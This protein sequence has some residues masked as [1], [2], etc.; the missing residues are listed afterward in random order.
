MN[1]VSMT[2]IPPLTSSNNNLSKLQPPPRTN[3]SSIES[4]M[5]LVNRCGPAMPRPLDPFTS[6]DL[7]NISSVNRDTDI[8]RGRWEGP[9]FVYC[10]CALAMIM[11]DRITYIL[12]IGV[13]KDCCWP[14]LQFLGIYSETCGRIV[15]S[16]TH[17]KTYHS[18]LFR[19]TRHWELGRR[20][21]GVRGL[22]CPVGFLC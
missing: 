19:R 22:S 16:G 20:W 12:E 5:N 15:V 7:K 13:S 4:P 2:D 11:K 6:K 14:C 21:R 18:W 10:E 3:I 8:T 1:I 9:A 17:G